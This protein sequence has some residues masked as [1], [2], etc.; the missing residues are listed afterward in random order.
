MSKSSFL[1]EL[2]I[3]SDVV[4]TAIGFV[5]QRIFS[6]FSYFTALFFVLVFLVAK[7]AFFVALLSPAFYSVGFSGSAF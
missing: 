7:I 4:S 3:A 6:F 5:M 1:T 2:G